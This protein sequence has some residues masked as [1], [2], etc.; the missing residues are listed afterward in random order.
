MQQA[1]HEASRISRAF[2]ANPF[3]S[4]E[5]QDGFLAILEAGAALSSRGETMTDAY[6]RQRCSGAIRDRK[7]KQRSVESREVISA[8]RMEDAED[9]ATP[10]VRQKQA[11]LTAILDQA[12]VR[13]PFRH[14]KI[15]NLIYVEGE[16]IRDIAAQLGMA[17]SSIHRIHA[18]ALE[19]LR[20]NLQK[21]NITCVS[22]VF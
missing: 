2:G 5:M 3:L 11:Q 12:M 17:V 18:L 4:D 15:I 7:R 19:K 20:N 6:M 22:D 1:L 9:P 16:D 21:K 13:F 10:E 14:R 8:E